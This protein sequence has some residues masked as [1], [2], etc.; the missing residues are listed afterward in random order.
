MK[1]SMVIFDLDGTILLSEE[2]YGKAFK[3]VLQDNQVKESSEHPQ[4]AGIGVKENWEILK[5]R[6]KIKK[7]V[8]ELT[9]QTQEEYLKT[10]DEVQIRE[11]FL[12]FA[13]ELKRSGILIALATSN[14]WWLVEED[15]A[16][17]NL[18][19]LFD[20]IT[21]GEEVEYNKPDPD[22]FLET[23]K[24]AGIDSSECLVIEDSIAGVKAAKAAGMKVIAMRS[25]Y[26]EEKDLKQ[27]DKVVSSFNQIS[28]KILL[29]I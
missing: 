6:Y 23:A 11:G 14:A 9:E 1:L 4:I 29:N 17:F 24:K 13:N 10:L 3:K 15:L 19:S 16:Y 26:E 22:L 18:E 8:E 5:N 28:P 25:W 20:V 21:T 7:S 12:K 2:A 27:A